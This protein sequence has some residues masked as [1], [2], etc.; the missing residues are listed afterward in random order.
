MRPEL[1]SAMIANVSRDESVVISLLDAQNYVI[2]AWEGVL[3]FENRVGNPLVPVTIDVAR[4]GRLDRVLI[5]SDLLGVVQLPGT[6]GQHLNLGDTLTLQAGPTGFITFALD[7]PPPRPLTG[8]A[9]SFVASGAVHTSG[10]GISVPA[11]GGGYVYQ[12]NTNVL[13]ASH[14]T[15]PPSTPPIVF[16]VL[17]D[18]GPLRPSRPEPDLTRKPRAIALDGL[19]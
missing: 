16:S 18:D 9:T 12:S 1:F 8:I 10:N 17:H 7:E 14:V 5:A 15:F 13:N 11:T 2:G 3:R 4:R 6:Y 19:D